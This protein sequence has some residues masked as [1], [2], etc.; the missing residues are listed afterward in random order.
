MESNIIHHNN[1]TTVSSAKKYLLAPSFYCNYRWVKPPWG[2]RNN[3]N[4]NNNNKKENK[5]GGC[6]EET[7]YLVP[8]GHSLPWAVTPRALRAHYQTSSCS[9]RNSGQQT[10]MQDDFTLIEVTLSQ[11]Y[12]LSIKVRW[13]DLGLSFYSNG[14]QIPPENGSFVHCPNLQSI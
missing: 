4:N 5:R 1:T 13:R 2:E 6:L 11:D 9:C 10:A 12:Q 7:W 14:I 8:W 3:S